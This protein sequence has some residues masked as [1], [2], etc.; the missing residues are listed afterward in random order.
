LTII[1]GQ[2]LP[3]N[4]KLYYRLLNKCEHWKLTSTIKVICIAWKGLREIRRGIVRYLLAKGENYIWG[5]LGAP[6]FR[7]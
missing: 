2:C 6:C 1:T 5:N 7:Y 3:E 4:L